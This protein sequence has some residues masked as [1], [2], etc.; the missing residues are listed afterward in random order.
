M[1]HHIAAQHRDIARAIECS[2]VDCDFEAIERGLVL[3]VEKARI[4][5][6]HDRGLAAARERCAFEHERAAFGE[7]PRLLGRFRVRQQHG[8]AKMHAGCGMSENM[9]Q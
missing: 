8:V 2:D 3:G 7:A 4:A 9:R 5:H 1:F 6:G